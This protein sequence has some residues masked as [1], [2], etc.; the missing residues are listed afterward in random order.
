MKNRV[1]AL[2]DLLTFDA[3]K[4]ASCFDF[5]E[6][7]NKHIIITGASGLVGINFLASL[8]QIAKKVNGMKIFPIIHSD[9]SEFLLPLLNSKTVQVFKGN[10]TDSEFIKTLPDA[11]IIIHAAGSGEPSKFMTDTLASLKINTLTTFMLFEKLNSNGKFLFI[12]S[13][14]IYNGLESAK[15]SENQIG[16]TNTDHPRAC[17]IEGKRTGE[18]ICTLYRQ[19]GVNASS[20]RLSLTY[21]PGTRPNDKRVLPSFIQKAIKGKIELLDEGEATRTFCYIS[22]AIEMMWHII[23]HGTHSCYNVGGVSAI[24]INELAY[25]IGQLLNVPVVI[26]N[27]K[28]SIAGAPSSVFL[29]LDR[30]MS[31]YKKESYIELQEGLEKTIVWHKNLIE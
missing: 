29:N 23:L 24:K 22:D 30:I 11:D 5:Q 8:L 2:S 15:Y 13:S 7:T 14:D 25:L 4:V 6:L 16:T 27:V 10:L 12:S 1:E 3:M 18:T 17:Y 19:Q 21:G 28:K 9:P 31:E 20:V 26:P